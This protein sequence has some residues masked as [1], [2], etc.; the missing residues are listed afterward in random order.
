MLTQR[1]ATHGIAVSG[2]TSTPYNVSVGG[3]D[4]GGYVHGHS[5]YLL[6]GSANGST[7][8]SALSYIPE[9]PWND[10]CAGEI[11]AT[12]SGYASPFGSDGFCNSII[13]EFFTW[14]LRLEAEARV[15]A[16]RECHPPAMS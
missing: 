9:I 3:T 1:V 8:G 11:F 13:A 5:K 2:Y 15:A 7:D 4:F 10:S 6:W 12:F 16:R 14:T